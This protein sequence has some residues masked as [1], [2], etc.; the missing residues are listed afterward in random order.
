MNGSIFLFNLGG[1]GEGR[2]WQLRH[3]GIRTILRHRTRV[4]R[5]HGRVE[6][7]VLEARLVRV[8]DLVVGCHTLYGTLGHRR[9]G[10]LR[11]RVLVLLAAERDA[12]TVERLADDAV[13]PRGEIALGD[14]RANGE[15][16]PV[17]RPLDAIVDGPGEDAHVPLVR[18]E[19]RRRVLAHNLERAAIL[20]GVRPKEEG[21]AGAR[22]VDHAPAPVAV[23]NLLRPVRHVH[24]RVG[25]TNVGC[26]VRLGEEGA[27]HGGAMQREVGRLG[28]H[29][30]A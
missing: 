13:G 26:D 22:A 18:R 30:E 2:R 12:V 27:V 8:V 29:V 21:V 20:G 1:R 23:A 15:V 5:A 7:R 24:P 14:T 9:G 17:L 19:L 3:L 16:E 28:L 10:D 4:R 11:S 25:R 6:A